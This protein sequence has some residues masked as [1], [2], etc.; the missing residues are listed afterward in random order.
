MTRAGGARRKKKRVHSLPLFYLYFVFDPI[1]V[2]VWMPLVMRWGLCSGGDW[3][4][5]DQQ[6]FSVMAVLA[7]LQLSDQ[8]Q[9]IA[10]NLQKS[11]LEK[12][13]QPR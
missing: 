6:Q 4:L 2:Q 13:D 11:D 12:A 9:F 1:Y 7:K 5:S 3:R 10:Q 8:Q